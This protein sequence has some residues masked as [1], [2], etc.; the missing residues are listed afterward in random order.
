MGLSLKDSETFGYLSK[1]RDI[2]IA[3][4]M[5][6][7]GEEKQKILKYTELSEDEFTKE[8]VNALSKNSDAKNTH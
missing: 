8:V 6:A 3:R 7:E 4:I 2:K 1:E 5:Y